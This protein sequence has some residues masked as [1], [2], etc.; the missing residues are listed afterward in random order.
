[1]YMVK[2]NNNKKGLFPSATALSD[3]FGDL[4][5]YEYYNCGL[6]KGRQ[7]SLPKDLSCEKDNDITVVDLSNNAVGS[8]KSV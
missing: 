7:K 5:S 8:D 1:M 6:R 4:K 3:K 2:N